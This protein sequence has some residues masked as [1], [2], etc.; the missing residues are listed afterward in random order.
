MTY[1]QK[2]A[3]ILKLLLYNENKKVQVK[4]FSVLKYSET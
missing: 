3:A 4:V 1:P 2:Q